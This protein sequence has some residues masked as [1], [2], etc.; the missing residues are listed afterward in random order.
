MSVGG[1]TYKYYYCRRK[2]TLIKIWKGK[3][4]HKNI[5]TYF[6]LFWTYEGTFLY[7]RKFKSII[8]LTTNFEYHKKYL[9]RT[10]NAISSTI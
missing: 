5:S 3:C 4:Y 8:N 1:K 7:H 2:D 6:K 10:F 9:G